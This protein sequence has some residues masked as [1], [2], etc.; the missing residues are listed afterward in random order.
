MGMTDHVRTNASVLGQLLK[1]HEYVSDNDQKRN[2]G[3]A[4]WRPRRVSQRDQ[5]AHYIPPLP[6]RIPMP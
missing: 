6:S 3:K 4:V 2:G 1:E 5:A